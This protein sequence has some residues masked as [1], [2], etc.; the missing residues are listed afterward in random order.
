MVTDSVKT[1]EWKGEEDLPRQETSS[2]EA[3]VRLVFVLILQ[4][5]WQIA[6][7]YL[8]TYL[9]HGSKVHLEKLTRLQLVKKFPHFM[10]PE[11]SLPHSQVPAT[12]PYPEPA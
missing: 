4:E 8:P 3:V 6:L 10:E 1:D 12:C 9:L 11:D 5:G 7:T 2:E